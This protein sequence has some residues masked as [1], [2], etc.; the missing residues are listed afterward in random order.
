[1]SKISFVYEKRREI[2]PFIQKRIL[3]FDDFWNPEIQ[4][5]YIF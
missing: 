5:L 2:I 4:I 3:D 1:M